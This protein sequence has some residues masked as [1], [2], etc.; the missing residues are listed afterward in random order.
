M[1]HF[2]VVAFIMLFCFAVLPEF[3]VTDKAGENAGNGNIKQIEIIN[4]ETQ[5]NLNNNQSNNEKIQSN[6][7][8]E[9]K[10][11]A[12][13]DVKM[14]SSDE[15]PKVGEEKIENG[16]NKKSEPTINEYVVESEGESTKQASSNAFHYKNETKEN[17]SENN[18]L[19]KN[20]VQENEDKKI[21]NAN[22]QD[23]DDCECKSEKQECDCKDKEKK[24]ESENA[25]QFQ[26][27]RQGNSDWLKHRKEDKI[28]N[29]NFVENKVAE[30]EDENI[31]PKVGL[32]EGG[33][34]NKIIESTNATTDKGKAKE[35]QVTQK[36][37]PI[38][39]KMINDHKQ[40]RAKKEVPGTSKIEN[41]KMFDLNKEQPV[42]DVELLGIIDNATV[43]MQDGIVNVKV[44]A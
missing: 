39:D 33:E 21:N 24:C 40:E 23:C 35:E 5:N 29:S 6:P 9:T 15:M 7:S 37:L 36:N 2:I 10:A 43:I 42:Y 20:S 38:E 31:L 25:N 28:N 22:C 18:S 19:E 13:A 44:G 1:K 12:S 3:F 17:E 14:S 26:I 16:A 8:N 11:N 4:N 41:M 32:Y 30:N 27:D 34:D